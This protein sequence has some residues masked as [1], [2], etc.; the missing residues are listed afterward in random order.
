MRITT[1]TER[2]LADGFA[3]A[4][5]RLIDTSAEIGRLEAD[6]SEVFETRRRLAAEVI[7]AQNDVAELASALESHGGDI[8]VSS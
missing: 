4:K 5:K 2:V 1:I 3:A 7:Q 8:E 6:Y